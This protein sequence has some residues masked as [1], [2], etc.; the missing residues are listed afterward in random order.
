[1]TDVIIDE[2]N[3]AQAE[4]WNGGTGG[5]WAANQAFFDAGM[6][7]HHGALMKAAAIKPDDR[8]L[9]L[10]CGNGQTTR[11]AARAAFEGSATGIDLSSAML[12]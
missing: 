1:M 4:E 2:G 7:E 6:R 9:D 12:E 11:D 10:G 8:V 3:A 5:V